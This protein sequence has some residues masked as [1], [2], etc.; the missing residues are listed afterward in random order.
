MM[1]YST[2]TW[3]LVLF[4]KQGPLKIEQKNWT[5]NQGKIIGNFKG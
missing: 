1:K 5:K 2:Y 3:N 4:R